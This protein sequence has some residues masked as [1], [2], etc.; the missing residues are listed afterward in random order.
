MVNQALLGKWLWRFGCETN[1]LWRQVIATKY[2]ETSGGWCTKVGRGLQGCGMW[3][4]IREGAES[5]FGHVL[6]VV[7]EGLCILFW[8]DLWCG[9]IPL[10]DLYPDLFSCALSKD[11]WIS[12]L[13]IVT[14]NG[15]SRSWNIQFHW[16]PDDWE[17]ERVNAFYEHIYSK[18]PRGVGV[19]SLFWMLSPNGVFDVCS[20][21]NSLS[22]PP[23]I[24][25][26]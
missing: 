16:A 8:Y 5:F 9:H 4:N 24:S 10:K 15:G 3:K 14:S 1:H 19:D 18:M 12:E 11:A 17:V 13:I 25:F 22:A 23:T 21:Y 20:F 6:Y 2:G 7:G 26:P